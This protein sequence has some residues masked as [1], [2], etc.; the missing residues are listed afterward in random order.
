[1]ERSWAFPR[2]A[3]LHVQGRGVA[4]AIANA[5]YDAVGVWLTTFPFTTE[6]VYDAI[7]AHGASDEKVR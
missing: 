4:P 2:C 5:V 7:Q 6:R 1:M 3:P